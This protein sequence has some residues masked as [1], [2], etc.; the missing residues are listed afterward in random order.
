L[1]TGR[2]SARADTEQPEPVFEPLRD[3]IDSQDFDP[4]RRQLNGQ[5]D[6]VQ[7]HAYLGDGERVPIGQLESRL[8]GCRATNKQTHCL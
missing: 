7:T 5:R 8:C 3:L 1:V 2:S 4:R 6:P